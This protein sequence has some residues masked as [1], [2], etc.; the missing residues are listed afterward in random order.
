MP[1]ETHTVVVV[2][3][4][5]RDS[6]THHVATRVAEAVS[7]WGGVELVDLQREEF[8]PRF[9]LEDRRHY[10]A[11]S[12]AVPL[13]VRS[14]QARLDRATDL[15]LVFP[16]YWWSMPAML[17]GW[18]DRVFISG[19]AFEIDDEGHVVPRLGALRIHL[20]PVAGADRGT[21]ERH[22]YETSMRTQILHGLVEYCGAA[23]GATTFVHDSE[24]LSSEVREGEVARAVDAITEV[25]AGR[26][27]ST[28]D[29]SRSA[30]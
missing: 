7:R 17:K 6:L 29:V 14:E 1:T 30:R 23:L 28:S 5:D 22:G 8:D 19:W 27:R 24:D 21:Y 10:R 11:E 12:A 26:V 4:P 18:V 3:H 16:V 25:Y 13:D 9:S 15:V 20:V 2:A